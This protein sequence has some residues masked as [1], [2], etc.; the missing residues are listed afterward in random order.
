MNTRKQFSSK[1]PKLLPQVG[2]SVVGGVVNYFIVFCSGFMPHE[3]WGVFL[4]FASG[5]IFTYAFLYVATSVDEFKERKAYSLKAYCKQQKTVSY[6]M[7]Q[8]LKSYI[9]K[10]GSVFPSDKDLLFGSI[11]V[12]IALARSSRLPISNVEYFLEDVSKDQ[13]LRIAKKLGKHPLL[14]FK[15]EE[16]G[17]FSISIGFKDLERG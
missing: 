3:W 2:L 6:A 9:K 4:A 8:V 5:F 12:Y 14:E 10:N 15:V 1:G 7:G 16:S 13:E 11:E 17:S